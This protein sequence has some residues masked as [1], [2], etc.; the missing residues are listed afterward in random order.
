MII[1]DLIFL[2]CVH[3]YSTAYQL[4]CNSVKTVKF[5]ECVLIPAHQ[6]I[7][8]TVITDKERFLTFTSDI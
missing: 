7:E 2:R 4:K 6:H 3:P 5:V 8:D 1:L